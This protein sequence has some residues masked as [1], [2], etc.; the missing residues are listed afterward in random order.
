MVTIS[1][2]NFQTFTRKGEGFDIMASRL[3]EMDSCD[4]EDYD[5]NLAIK[6]RSVLDLL[7]RIK[8]AAKMRKVDSSWQVMS[9]SPKINPSNASTFYVYYFSLKLKELLVNVG[10]D[11]EILQNLVDEFP[12]NMER[13]DGSMSIA[14]L[15]DLLSGEIKSH[16][17]NELKEEGCLVNMGHVQQL[18][19]QRVRKTLSKVLPRPLPKNA[20]N[21]IIDHFVHLQDENPN[22]DDWRIDEVEKIKGSTSEDDQEDLSDEDEYDDISMRMKIADSTYVQ[23][24]EYMDHYDI[25]ELSMVFNVA[26]KCRQDFIDTSVIKRIN[27]LQCSILQG[28]IFGDKTKEEAKAVLESKW[29]KKVAKRRTEDGSGPSGIKKPRK[30]GIC[31]QP[32]HVRTYCPQVQASSEELAERVVPQSPDF[33]DAFTDF[34]A[35]SKSRHK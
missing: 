17:F 32:G 29:K 8:E 16:S 6:Y 2:L 22:N 28:D 1:R 13:T 11:F 20:L 25:E 35:K 12:A 9:F 3:L 24:K 23:A 30:C 34:L 31:R 7:K 10:K 4:E 18:A 33:Q 19:K 5:E 15:F 14:S 26:K 21:I 27:V